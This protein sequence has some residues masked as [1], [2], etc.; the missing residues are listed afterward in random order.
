LHFVAYR[1]K[2]LKDYPNGGG[3]WVMGYCVTLQIMKHINGL[4]DIFYTSAEN[5][6]S[7]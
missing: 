2:I 3:E 4:I 7:T 6:P 5:V 1:S